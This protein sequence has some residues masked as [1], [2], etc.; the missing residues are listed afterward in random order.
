VAG[1]LIPAFSLGIPG[2]ST[3]AIFLVGMTIHGL[4][5]GADL[6]STNATIMSLIYWAFI[7]GQLSYLVIG[8]LFSKPLAKITKISNTILFP[9]Y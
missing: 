8:L 4:R 3:S 6:Y 5:P 2:G 7:V 9:S 1:E